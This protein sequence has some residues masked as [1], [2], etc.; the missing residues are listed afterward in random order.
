MVFHGCPPSPDAWGRLIVATPFLSGDSRLQRSLAAGPITA[1]SDSPPR[2][3]P[4]RGRPN[5]TT[6]YIRRSQAAE[7]ACRRGE[8]PAS[9]GRRPHPTDLLNG[10][11]CSA[12]D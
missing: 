4:C 7:K 3:E 1:S 12:R 10:V 2:H 11:Q 6:P 5:K 9:E 8:T